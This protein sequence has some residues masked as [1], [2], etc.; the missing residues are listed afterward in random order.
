MAPVALPTVTL[1]LRLA[2]D[3]LQRA[4]QQRPR[5]KAVQKRVDAAEAKARTGG[6]TNCPTTLFIHQ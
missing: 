1:R 6:C 3:E 4:Q 2:I 5:T